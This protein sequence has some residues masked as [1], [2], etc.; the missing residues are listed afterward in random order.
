MSAG[1]H[2]TFTT[3]AASGDTQL[4]K[5]DVEGSSPFARS[6]C[7]ESDFRIDHESAE[8]HHAR[9]GVSASQ[10]KLADECFLAFYLRHIKGEA[11]LK[12]S[13]AMEYGSLLHFWAEV[14]EESFWKRAISY[15]VSV[16]TATG[17]VGKE[18]KK[19][20]EDQPAD[21]IVLTPADRQK[22]YDQTR[23]ILANKAAAALLEEAVDREFNC[24]WMWNGHAMRCRVDGATRRYW[25]DLKTT[26]EPNPK[27]VGW[28]FSKFRYGI[29]D[30]VYRSARRASGMWPDQPM[31]FIVTSTVW[32]HLCSV[33]TL[34]LEVTDAQEKRCLRL[35]DEIKSRM[36]WGQWYPADHGEVTELE[37]PAAMREV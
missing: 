6:D 8:V 36:E 17:L 27:A 30:A 20:L 35:L 29:Q 3:S 4:P 15:P 23:Q 31:R 9:D 7:R 19:W 24:Q 2:S 13:A 5:L 33:V 22:L 10:L 14:G 25:F 32:P 12:S 26:S 28:S 18:A 34:P 1:F 37:C 11:P 21:A 16:L